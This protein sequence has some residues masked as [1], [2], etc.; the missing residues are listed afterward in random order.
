MNIIKSLEEF[1]K[2][3]NITLWK[4]T[5]IVSW[6]IQQDYLSFAKDAKDMEI[7]EF[8]PWAKELSIPITLIDTKASWLDYFEIKAIIDTT[9]HF[10]WKVTR[11]LDIMSMEKWSVIRFDKIKN[12]N[13]LEKEKKWKKT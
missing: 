11:P 1:A 8:Q 13:I 7:V 10:N 6:N 4:N 3:N 2:S 12:D 9:G 5:V